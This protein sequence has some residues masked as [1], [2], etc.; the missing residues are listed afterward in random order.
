MND[1]SKEEREVRIIWLKMLLLLQKLSEDFHSVFAY[2][3][4]YLT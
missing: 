3:I 1:K 2:T 4:I